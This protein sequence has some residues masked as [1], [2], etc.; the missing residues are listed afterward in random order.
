MSKD[1]FVEKCMNLFSMSDKDIIK[2]ILKDS[3]DKCNTCIDDNGDKFPSDFTVSDITNY[4]PTKNTFP[5]FAYFLCTSKINKKD[6]LKNA[7]S[8]DFDN[9]LH[10]KENDK[11]KNP[12]IESRR[13]RSKKTNLP[14]ILGLFTFKNQKGES[15]VISDIE[16]IIDEYFTGYLEISKSIYG[17]NTN[18]YVLI[19]S[20]SI[21]SRWKSNGHKNILTWT[22]PHEEYNTES[23]RKLMNINSTIHV[24]RVRNEV[25]RYMG[26]CES[27]E[28]IDENNGSC[29]MNV[30]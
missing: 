19:V 21:D 16:K 12:H 7:I 22:Y 4:K 17:D 6:L 1:I 10:K 28:N 8:N 13:T 20:D 24:I 23:F 18:N 11:R 30:L 26:K 25:L 14:S 27:I 3:L 29:V 5:D 9:L 2:S 15:E